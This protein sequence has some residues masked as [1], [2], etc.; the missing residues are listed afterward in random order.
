MHRVDALI[1]QPTLCRIRTKWPAAR[2]EG[3]E[4]DLAYG[5]VFARRAEL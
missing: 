1:G 5:R 4:V 3:W 2:A